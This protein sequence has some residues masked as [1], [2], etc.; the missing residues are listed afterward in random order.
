MANFATTRQED[1]P[2][3]ESR[4]EADLLR[5]SGQ[6]TI[7][8]VA[9]PLGVGGLGVVRLSGT[10]AVAIADSLFRPTGH[11]TL[12]Q[13]ESH[14]LM[15]GWIRDLAN[16]DASRERH[17][18]D[19]KKGVMK[20]QGPDESR[21]LDEA[22]AVVMRTPRSYTREDVVELQCHGGPLILRTVVEQACRLG[23]R[24]A[25]PGEFTLRAFLNGR[26]DLTQA[27]AVGDIPH[28]RTRMG[29]TVTVNQLR[30]RLLKDITALRDDVAQ[31]AAL[32]AA[33]I[34]FPEEDVV[35]AR[36]DELEARLRVV[37]ERLERLLATAGRGRIMREGVGLALIG[38]P[39]VG[40]SSLL[41]ALLRENR[42]IVTEIPGTTR[43]TLEEIA[44]LSG[45][46]VRLVDTA[47]IREGAGQVEA[48]G[49]ERARE[50]MAKADLVLLVLDGASPLQPEDLALL[51]EVRSEATLAVINKGD[52]LEGGHTVWDVQAQPVAEKQLE[53]LEQVV[54]SAQDGTGLEALEKIII[55]RALRGE[56]A[57][58]EE[59][60]L[61]NLR[62]EEA[63]RKTREA[64]IHT[65]DALDEGLGEEFL[66]V[67]LDRVLMSL[68]EIVGQTTA[69]DLLGRIFAEFCI[70]K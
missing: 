5:E 13:A 43:D 23:G 70:G 24:L 42:A 6:E 47:G 1:S 19:E 30:G 61:T 12:T 31:V 50:A 10:D 28:S 17:V 41:N 45:L 4:Q 65:L 7:V 3:R 58:A 63:A 44:D 60:L 29:L 67:D 51:E 34:D 53:A 25:R 69:D 16:D 8:A 48:I 2:L 15:H 37:L 54:V 14:R 11:T 26:I 18:L 35:F 52:L 57:L 55:N 22:M 9:T 20:S 36:K 33:G 46:A 27:E 68:G 21:M 39:N 38:R 62:Q 40:K 64:L 66:A 56:T 59:P 32:V 49:I